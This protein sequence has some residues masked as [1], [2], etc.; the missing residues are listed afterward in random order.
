MVPDP[1]MAPAASSSPQLL[2][3]PADVHMLRDA[4][5]SERTQHTLN[6]LKTVNYSIN[7]S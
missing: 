5:F 4:G 2:S 1:A 7:E 3:V 6:L